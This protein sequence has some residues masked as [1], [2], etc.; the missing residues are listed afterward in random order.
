M[1]PAVRR[2]VSEYQVDLS[3]VVATGREMPGANSETMHKRV[4]KE[5]VLKYLESIGVSSSLAST[6]TPQR[7]PSAAPTPPPQPS[8]PPPT[9]ASAPAPSAPVR[10]PA[11][12]SLSPRI[13]SRTPA[14]DTVVQLRGIRRAMAKSMTASLKVKGG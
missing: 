12:S 6:S 3:K 13:V 4:L 14:A 9:P 2:L 7:T 11:P 8:T 1:T 10:A 5:D